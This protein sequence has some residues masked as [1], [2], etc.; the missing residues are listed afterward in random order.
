MK[1]YKF[2]INEK[3]YNVVVKDIDDGI[4]ELEVNGTPYEVKV[5]L[6]E[7]KVS[8][9]PILVRKEVQNKPGENKV[10]E[11]LAPMPMA[12][13]PS[14]KTI[15]APL[16]GSVIKINVEEGSTFQEGDVLM[17]ME[18]MKMENNILAE[19][20]GTIHKVCISPGDS[21]MQDQPLFEI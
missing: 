20:S 12:A 21:V 18:S 4:A 6:Q 19:K 3:D 7:Q 15:N 8:K 14:A 5:H 1:K 2:T 13:K 16:P 17:I 9:T 11:K 10:A